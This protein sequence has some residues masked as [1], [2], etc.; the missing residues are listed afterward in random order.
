VLAAVDLD[1]TRAVVEALAATQSEML[2]A[3][4]PERVAA[5]AAVVAALAHPLFR[6]AARATVVRRETPVMLREPDGT[7]LEGVVDLAFRDVDTGG[8]VW[9]VVDYKTDQELE[10]KQAAYE[11]QV[12]SYARAI[13]VATGERV[14]GVL[15]RV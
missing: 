12:M 2:G 3:K 7:L 9:T 8:A 6:R 15:L 1:A 13:A 10:G 5:V 4:N 11:A 14:R